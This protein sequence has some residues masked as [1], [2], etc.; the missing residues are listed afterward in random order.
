ME[1]KIHVDLSG[2]G[3][4]QSCAASEGIVRCCSHGEVKVIFWD[5]W[6]GFSTHLDMV[7]PGDFSSLSVS[8]LMN[9]L[10]LIGKERYCDDLG[11]YMLHF[12]A[13]ML[14]SVVY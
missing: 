8:Q 12:V 11:D 6:N 5:G 2:H 13:L 1:G 4:M 10:I 9:L 3:W 7:S 14:L